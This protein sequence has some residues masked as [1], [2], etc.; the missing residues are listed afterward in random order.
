MFTSIQSGRNLAIMTKLKN[1]QHT[2][3]FVTLTK[4]NSTLYLIAKN[5]WLTYWRGLASCSSTRWTPLC[6]PGTTEVA[7]PEK[8]FLLFNILDPLR[9]LKCT[10]V[11]NSPLKH[12]DELF[13][14][15][16]ES[17]VL[18]RSRRQ[19]PV[20]FSSTAVLEISPFYV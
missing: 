2:F 11:S 10:L 18:K 3:N 6:T 14:L 19:P 20:L 8:F 7:E 1:I 15:E 16:C 5:L 17:F 4:L 9:K 12:K 13:Q